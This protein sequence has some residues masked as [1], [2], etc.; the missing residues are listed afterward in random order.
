M[1]NGCRKWVCVVS[2]RSHVMCVLHP[3]ISW[4][5]TYYFINLVRQKYLQFFIYNWLQDN[6]FNNWMNLIII[7]SINNT[8]T[9][10]LIE[11]SFALAKV[12]N[13]RHMCHNVV[14]QQFGIGMYLVNKFLNCV[15]LIQ[16]LKKSSRSLKSNTITIL[17]QTFHYVLI[18]STFFKQ[19]KGKIVLKNEHLSYIEIIIFEVA[20]HGGTFGAWLNIGILVVTFVIKTMDTLDLKHCNSR[21]AIKKNYKK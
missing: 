16:L 5:T 8:T 1:I 2:V 20:R 4:M 18:F 19:Q 11:F 13:P 14:Y 17:V 12:S 3:N 7:N 9:H 21:Q 6:Y 15:H 10:N